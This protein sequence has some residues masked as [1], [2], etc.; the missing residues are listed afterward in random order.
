MQKTKVRLLV[1]Q[2][3]EVEVNADPETI[4]Q[5][6]P[7]FGNSVEIFDRHKL[8]Y[9]EIYGVQLGECKKT[10]I[11]CQSIQIQPQQ[12]K[13]LEFDLGEILEGQLG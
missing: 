13:N 1:C 12:S 4:K 10:L 9:P 11:D 7:D 2:V 3:Y 8:A 6:Y 5:H